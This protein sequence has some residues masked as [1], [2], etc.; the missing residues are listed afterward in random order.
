M[1]KP[2]D[3]QGFG[4]D[5]FHE[6]A[7]P[8][9]FLA[10]LLPVITDRDELA[11]LLL[12]FDALTT[13][14]QG[15]V[16]LDPRQMAED[17]QLMAAFGADALALQHALQLAR[18]HDALIH[19]PQADGAGF[20]MINTPQNQLLAKQIQQ[21]EV[22][23]QDLPRVSRISDRP[24]IFQ[25]YEENIGMLTP[26]LAEMLKADEVEFS[27]EWISDAI[28][29]AVERN[30]RNWK[31]VRAILASWKKEGRNGKNGQGTEKS[32]RRYQKSW[33]EPGETK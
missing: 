20:Y 22:K 5:D 15:A 25:L 32:R 6:V 24:N 2:A 13:A 30:V 27:A 8:Q 11:L 17:P 12:I 29:I 18:E 33:L 1:V 19:V 9:A 28:K 7:L 4:D 16:R 3:F 10:Q 26:M 23:P 14:E 31:Y 21:G